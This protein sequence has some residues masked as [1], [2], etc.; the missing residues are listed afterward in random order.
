MIAVTARPQAD[1][2]GFLI[3]TIYAL[4][5]GRRGIYRGLA[6]YEIVPLESG[7]NAT[8]RYYIWETSSDRRIVVDGPLVFE[9]VRT[10]PTSPRDGLIVGYTR[11]QLPAVPR[12]G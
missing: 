11:D 4:P 5:G 1:P 8:T 12:E 2:P 7:R 6:T 9:L 10:D 3:G